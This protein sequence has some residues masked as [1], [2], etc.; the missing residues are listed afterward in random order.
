MP[1]PRLEV[2]AAGFPPRPGVLPRPR[3]GSEAAGFTPRPDVLPRPRPGAETVVPPRARAAGVLPRPRQGLAVAAAPETLILRPAVV[4]DSRHPRPRPRSRVEVADTLSDDVPGVGAMVSL[5]SV[6]GSRR[7]GRTAVRRRPIS[8]PVAAG[9]GEE[10]RPAGG[11]A[12]SVAGSRRDGRRAVRRR[13]TSSPVAA[14]S[15]EEEPRPAVWS[16]HEAISTGIPGSAES[17]P[18]MKMFLVWATCLRTLPSPP[19]WNK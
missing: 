16:R 1:R 9:S 11:P 3:P 7:D 5:A 12:L 2:E 18:M 10:P 19:D 6:V 4:V 15:G 13:P 17:C 8:S 14:G